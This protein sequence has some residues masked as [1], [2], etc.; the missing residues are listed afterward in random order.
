MLLL[1]CHHPIILESRAPYL[2]DAVAHIF[3]SP[4]YS[5]S[6]YSKL[7]PHVPLIA[8]RK[9]IRTT[10][11]HHVFHY[12]AVRVGCSGTAD[13]GGNESPAEVEEH[14]QSWTG[15]RL[16]QLQA[17]SRKARIRRKWSPARRVCLP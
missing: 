3:L 13:D 1:L 15:P 8:S 9:P 2:V 5:T 7:E 4:L 6:T 17:P 16:L 12:V 11:L 14:G 10:I